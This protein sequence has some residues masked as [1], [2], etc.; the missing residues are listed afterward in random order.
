MIFQVVAAH[1][2]RSLLFEVKNQKFSIKY[3]QPVLNAPED[4][5]VDRLTTQRHPL[6]HLGSIPC[7]SIRFATYLDV[8]AER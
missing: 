1:L 4:I 6:E 7:L 2:V 8:L 3:T 5:T